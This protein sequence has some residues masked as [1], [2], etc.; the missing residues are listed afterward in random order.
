MI[1]RERVA[2][3]A[4]LAVLVL[5]SGCAQ[6]GRSSPVDVAALAMSTA[7]LAVDWRQTRSAAV[8]GWSGG[9]WEGG[10]PAGQMIGAHPSVGRVDGYFLG[11]AMVNAALWAAL[12]RHWRSVI[13]GFVIGAEVYTVVGNLPTTRL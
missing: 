8:D 9:R 10:V 4:V 11:A 7:S 1:L 13:P 5:G 2:H 12:P 3:L 6:F